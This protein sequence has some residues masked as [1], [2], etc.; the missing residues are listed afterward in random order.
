[1][2]PRS[3]YVTH[4]IPPGD[5]EAWI[6]HAVNQQWVVVDGELLRP[7]PVFPLPPTVEE[8][9]DEPVTPSRFRWGFG[10]GA[11]W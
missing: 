1:V 2:K 8:P 3:A 9:A 6:S 7:G 11:D 4:G 10:R 5:V